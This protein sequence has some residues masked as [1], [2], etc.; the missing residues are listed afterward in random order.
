ML[1]RRRFLQAGGAVTFGGGIAGVLR[2]KPEAEAAGSVNVLV[3]GSLAALAEDVPGGSVEA[4]GSVAARRLVTEDARDP[5]ALALADPVLFDGVTDHAILFATNALVVAINPESPHAAAIRD[6]WAAAL[7]RDEVTVGRTDPRSDPLGY[8]TVLAMRIA[9]ERDIASP[10]IL[11]RSQVLPETALLRTL[12]MGQID[13]AFAYRSMA[14]EHDL[15]IVDLPAAIDFSDPAHADT[16]AT[17]SYDL[18]DRTVQGTPIRYAAAALTP[19]GE[20]WIERLTAGTA[21][22]ERHGFTVPSR[23]PTRT[24]DLG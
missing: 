2:S 22:L 7:A 17:V 11:D 5:D 24:S 1:D 20:P 23:Y 13:A 15:P 18:G 6:D 14:V 4:H 21:R 16:Y 8:R 12:E 9:A 10:S 3:A 19:A